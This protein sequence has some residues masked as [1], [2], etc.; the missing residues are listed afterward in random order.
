MCVCVFVFIC[1]CAKRRNVLEVRGAWGR[2][3]LAIPGYSIKRGGGMKTLHA[4]WCILK[5]YEL[6]LVIC[7]I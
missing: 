1:A 6:C 4:I 5:M 2:S 3:I 7:N